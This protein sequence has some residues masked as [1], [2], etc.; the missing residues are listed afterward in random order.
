MSS[1]SSRL[2][3]DCAC[4]REQPDDCTR[5]RAQSDDRDSGGEQSDDD[6]STQARMDPLRMTLKLADAEAGQ[7]IL[8]RLADSSEEVEFTIECVDSDGSGPCTVDVG[9]ITQKRLETARLAVE[10]GYYDVPKNATLSDL[11]ERQG[12]TESAVSQ[13][14]C[15]VER[16]LVKALVDSCG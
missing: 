10:S 8:Y 7:E 6:V 2:A 13:K 11:A 16:K 15:A 5:K 3:D 4:R 14:L 1:R 12:V 9:P